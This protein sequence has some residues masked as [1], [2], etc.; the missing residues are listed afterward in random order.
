MRVR[1]WQA[2]GVEGESARYGWEDVEVIFRGRW[3]E[4]RVRGDVAFVR[5]EER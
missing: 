5:E 4:E 2:S 1:E 3:V